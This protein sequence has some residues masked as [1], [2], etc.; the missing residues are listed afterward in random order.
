MNNLIEKKTGP[1]ETSFAISIPPS[2]R[3]KGA[4]EKKCG[5]WV[6]MGLGQ[7]SVSCHAIWIRVVLSQ[8]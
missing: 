7:W 1:I 8:R 4:R 3:R 6:L 2:K 5:N